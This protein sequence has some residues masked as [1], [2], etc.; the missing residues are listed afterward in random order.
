VF[1]VVA[2]QIIYKSKV[3]LDL[4]DH[5]LSLTNTESSF[6]YRIIFLQEFYTNKINNFEIKKHKYVF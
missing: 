5:F 3:D 6:F 4:E 1:A 2:I